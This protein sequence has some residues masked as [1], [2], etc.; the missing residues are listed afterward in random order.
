MDRTTYPQDR[1]AGGQEL[2]SGRGR[3]ARAPS[4]I[5][6]SGWKDIAFRVKD[7]ITN[8]RVM[9]VSAGVTFYLL[10][11]LGPLLAALVSVYGL[12]LDPAD[13]ASQTEALGQI[14]PG[15]GMDILTAQIE[16]LA[17][18][19]DSSLGIAFAISLAL[20]LWSANAGMKAMFQAM[21]V[22]YDETEDR[23]FVR[24]TLVTLAITVCSIIGILALLA[25]N[26]LFTS[27][28]AMIGV[29]LPTWMVNALTA[30]IALA[31]L[32]VFMAVLYRYGPSRESPQWSWITP[33]AVFAG[34]VAV[35]VSAAFTWYVANF[36][37]Y[38]E[39]Y[40]SLGAIVGFLTW[41]WLVVVVL[42]MGG[43]LN[44]EMEHQTAKDTTTGQR[45]PMGE[46]GATVAD[47]LGAQ[48]G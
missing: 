24:L 13:I 22:A 2:P 44:A 14:M 1:H 38:N 20:A 42:V 6:A 11:A 21:N 7:E 47:E 43:E 40:G 48:H 45:E 28:Q 33:G 16:R 25:F 39:T 46:R 26:T 19:Q 37:S 12:I 27:F 8:D 35:L 17:N 32:I 36:G 23:G 9:L 4:G 3:D 34:I 31:A 41:L 30:V 10:L 5:P 18:A 29:Q 15:G